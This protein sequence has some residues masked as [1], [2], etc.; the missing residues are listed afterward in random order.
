MFSAQRRSD[1]AVLAF[2]IA[3]NPTPRCAVDVLRAVS[4]VHVFLWLSSTFGPVAPAGESSESGRG[5][6]GVMAIG[7]KCPGSRWRR[8]D[9]TA[10][11][12]VGWTR[13]PRTGRRIE[14]GRGLLFCRRES[15][16]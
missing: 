8:W 13:G 6:T 9:L 15:P 1:K 16:G 14:K 7:A 5:V 10:L 12:R 3:G 2:V 11:R 4:R